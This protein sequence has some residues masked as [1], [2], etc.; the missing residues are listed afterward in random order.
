MKETLIGILTGFLGAVLIVA[1]IGVSYLVISGLSW[2]VCTS[3][4]LSWN[5][6]VPLGIMA[7]VILLRIV[8][9]YVTK[10]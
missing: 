4:G 9:K 8:F 2:L 10:E 6:W 3:F 5:W 7:A 1:A